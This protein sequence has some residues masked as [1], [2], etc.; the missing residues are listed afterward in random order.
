MSVGLFMT[1]KMPRTV[2]QRHL[3]D[4]KKKEKINLLQNY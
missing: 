2:Q 4:K 3:A 1:E